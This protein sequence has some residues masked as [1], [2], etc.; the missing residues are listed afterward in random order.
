MWWK[1]GLFTHRFLYRAKFK[2]KLVK[3]KILILDDLGLRK[4][5]A[6]EAHDLCELLEE[7]MAEKSTIIT[8]QLPLD[9][10]SEVI[11][12][13]VIADAIIDRL[14]HSS[15]KII[16]KGESYRKEKAKKLDQKVK[17]N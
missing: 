11:E 15:V 3:P 17:K 4:F 2:S 16:L 8:T 5:T 7:R 13:P 6:Q 14:I 10:W 9:H 1:L 12:D